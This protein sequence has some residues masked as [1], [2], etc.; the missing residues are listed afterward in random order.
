MSTAFRAIRWAIVQVRISPIS[1]RICVPNLVAFRRSCR[2]KGILTH[3]HTE[4]QC[5]FSNW[6]GYYTIRGREKTK[7]LDRYCLY[8]AQK[9]NYYV[10]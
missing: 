5:M 3:R 8:Q 7:S 1:I 9:L 6:V 10:G 4:G 2:K